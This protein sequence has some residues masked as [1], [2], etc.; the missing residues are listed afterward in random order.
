M[1]ILLITHGQTQGVGPLKYPLT[2][3][4]LYPPLLPPAAADACI[5][6]MLSLA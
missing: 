6:A 2:C 1:V 3:I 4:L 5:S